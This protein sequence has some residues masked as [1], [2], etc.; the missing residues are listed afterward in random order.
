MEAR[1]SSKTFDD[2]QWT[3][4][5]HIP[6]DRSLHLKLL[7]KIKNYCNFLKGKKLGLITAK[8]Q[9]VTGSEHGSRII[10]TATSRC[11]AMTN[12]GATK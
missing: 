1:C 5:R 12:E 7:E 8:M 3:T 10:Y 6:E 4:Q 9:L 11:L 2:F